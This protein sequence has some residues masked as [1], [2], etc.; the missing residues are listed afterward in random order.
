MS[1]KELT[2]KY[3]NLKLSELLEIYYEHAWGIIGA[4]NRVQMRPQYAPDE[5]FRKQVYAM[6]GENKTRKDKK[7]HGSF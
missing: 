6:S 7:L 3:S 1:A 4:K 2:N 5:T